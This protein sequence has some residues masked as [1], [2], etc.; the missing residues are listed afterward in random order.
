[1]VTKHNNKNDTPCS[2]LFFKRFIIGHDHSLLLFQFCKN[3]MAMANGECVQYYKISEQ[4]DGV[5]VV[6]SLWLLLKEFD[7]KNELISSF[8]SHVVLLLLHI[9]IS[10]KILKKVQFG[11]K[12]QSHYFCPLND[13]NWPFLKHF[14]SFLKKPLSA[15]FKLHYF[16]I[17]KALCGCQRNQNEDNNIIRVEG[18]RRR[19]KI[20]KKINLPNCFTSSAKYSRST[21]G[22]FFIN[23]C[24]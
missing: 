21:F 5:F 4:F 8:V 16:S 11:S 13:K 10:I 24:K 15:T 23:H 2:I 1:M 17:F 7:P 19:R 12:W 9:G 3:T 22:G 6:R 14:L 20:F 18:R